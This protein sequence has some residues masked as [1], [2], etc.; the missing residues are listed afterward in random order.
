M[1]FIQDNETEDISHSGD[2]SEQ[3]EASDVV[4]FGLSDDVE[5]QF[6]EKPV[7]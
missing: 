2:A 3:V 1:D 4:D 7:V 6:G 5:F